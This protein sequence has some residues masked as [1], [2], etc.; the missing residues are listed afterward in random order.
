M[1]VETIYI[2]APFFVFGSMFVWGAVLF[3]EGSRPPEGA[4]ELHVVGKQW[5]W[6]IQ[7]PTGRR[8]I[9]E[10]H[11]PLGQSVRLDMISEDVIHSF[12]V[13]AFRVKQDVLPGR[14]TQTWFEPSL[15]GEYHLFCAEYCGTDHSRMK[16]RVIVMEPSQY[17][18][19]LAGTLGQE[20]PIVAGRRLFE[21]LHCATCHRGAAGGA[22]RCPPLEN[23]FGSQ[24]KL[25]NGGMALADDGYIRESIVRPAAKV[26]AGYQPLMPSFEGQIDEQGLLDLIAYIKSL[27]TQERTAPL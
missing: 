7:H 13:P 8:E 2:G 4:L 11:V 17:Q 9:N 12:F 24:I 21:D 26:V 19:W 10:M 16:G 25:Q 15:L 14:Y 20:S 27:S 18:A 3:F 23:V 6:K 22:A 5:M 1:A